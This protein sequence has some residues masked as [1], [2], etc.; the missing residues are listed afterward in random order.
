MT[1]DQAATEARRRAMRLDVPARLPAAS[2]PEAEPSPKIPD[3][4]IGLDRHFRC[5]CGADFG[6]ADADWKPKAAR[7]IVSSASC[8]PHIRLHKELELRAFSCPH[9][10]TLLELEVCRTDE[11]SLQGVE[12][13]LAGA[14]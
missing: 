1:V 2:P 13:D 9:C 5:C 6:R 8:G 3:F 14:G 4:S 12:L 10:G 7:Q 11:E